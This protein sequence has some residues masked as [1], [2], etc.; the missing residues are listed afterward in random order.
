MMF[1]LIYIAVSVKLSSC[2]S[3]AGTDMST[4]LINAI[5]NNALVTFQYTHQ[6]DAASNHSHPSLFVVDSLPQI[7]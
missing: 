5:V 3:N 2:S 1:L 6:R 4:P 7:L